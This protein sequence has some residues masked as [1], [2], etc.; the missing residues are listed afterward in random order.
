MSEKQC[1]FSKM[2]EN[3][4][5]TPPGEE[6]KVIDFEILKGINIIPGDYIQG[7][8]WLTTFVYKSTPE[9][10]TPFRP[11]FKGNAESKGIS[12]ISWVQNYMPVSKLNLPL[13]ELKLAF[14]YPYKAAGFNIKLS[15]RNSILDSYNQ[16]M[17]IMYSKEEINVQDFS[18]ED[19]DCKP[20]P[21]LIPNDLE[22][23]N[24]VDFRGTISLF[25]VNKDEILSSLN[26]TAKLNYSNFL[27]DKLFCISLEND[28]SYIN[29]I[30][31]KDFKNSRYNVKYGSLMREFKFIGEK[32]LPGFIPDIPHALCGI[33]GQIDEVYKSPAFGSTPNYGLL[34]AKV[35]SSCCGAVLFNYA[36]GNV[37]S[38]STSYNFNDK[39]QQKNMENTLNEL[40]NILK[41]QLREYIKTN[42]KCDISFLEV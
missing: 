34:K 9:S 17:S 20:F 42:F 27:Q 31:F 41:K 14:L 15:F 29:T 39:N 13:K 10:Y 5:Y 37:V 4:K 3:Y 12:D 21:I 30:K 19:F 35:I 18:L 11:I 33:I 40:E 36:S 7:K 23:E 25:E 24:I 32:N 2:L 28:D 16:Y 1:T 26:A 8:A 22:T 6:S 38:L